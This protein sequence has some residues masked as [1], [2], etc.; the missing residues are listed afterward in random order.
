MIVSGRTA[1]PEG[2]EL[3]GANNLFDRLP[4]QLPS[5]SVAQLWSMDYPSESAY[6]IAGRV[7]HMRVNVVGN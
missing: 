5:G 6:G 2:H 4:N 1:R 3:S 7:W